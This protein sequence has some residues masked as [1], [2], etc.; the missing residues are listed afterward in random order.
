MQFI[1]LSWFTGVSWWYCTPQWQL[2]QVESC[3]FLVML[4]WYTGVSWWYCTP[5]WLLCQTESCSFIFILPNCYSGVHDGIVHLSDNCTKAES[6][7]SLC[8]VDIQVYHEGIVRLSDNCARAAAHCHVKM[9]IEMSSGQMLSSEKV[10]TC[11]LLCLKG[12]SFYLF[13][14]LLF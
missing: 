7:C 13:N 12:A 6:C 10:G 4:Y 14:Q 5:K 8:S 9:Y 11:F 3:T 2:Y 1:M